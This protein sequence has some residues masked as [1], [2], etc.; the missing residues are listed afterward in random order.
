MRISVPICR[1]SYTEQELYEDL[2]TYL[3]AE[4]YRAGVVWGSECLHAGGVM[5]SRSCMRIWV[6]ICRRSYAEQELYEDLSTDLQVELCSAGFHYRVCVPLKKR[7]CLL[8]DHKYSRP[9]HIPVTEETG[10]S[11]WSCMELVS[12]RNFVSCRLKKGS[13]SVVRIEIVARIIGCIDNVF[14]TFLWISK[15][16]V[17][18]SMMFLTSKSIAEFHRDYSRIS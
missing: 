3:P 2:S 4:L 16:S 18:K 6:P 15:S 10:K 1:R 5:Q 9:R 7:S 11:V 8:S 14:T 12:Y 17:K 13:K